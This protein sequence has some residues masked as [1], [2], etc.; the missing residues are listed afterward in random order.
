MKS[1][2]QKHIVE[3]IWID[4]VGQ[5]RSKN[6][7]YAIKPSS[8]QDITLWSFDGSSTG[9]A[10]THHSER[11]LKPVYLCNN[12]FLENSSLVLCAVYEDFECTIPALYNHYHKCQEVLNQ[13][14]ETEPWFGFEQ[15]YFL[16]KRNHTNISKTPLGIEDLT[17]CN[18]QGQYY[19]SI[20]AQNAF[21]R[22]IV[23]THLQYCLKAG[24]SIYGSNAEVAPGQ[25]EFQIGTVEGIE[26]AHQL[27]ISRYILLRVSEMFDCCVEFH[28]KP[29][30]HL[31]GSGCHTNFSTKATRN[32]G[33]LEIMTRD[34]FP[35][36]E[37]THKEHIENYGKHNELRLTGIHET[38]SIHS[39]SWAVA[40]RG[41]SIRVGIETF[42]NACGYFED[43]RPASNCDPYLV[44]ML[45]VKNTHTKLATD[46]KSEY[47]E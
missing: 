23:E 13:Y 42:K 24:I 35:R 14:I 11:F 29:F 9:Q 17:N 15:E 44:S 21:G 7:I 33:G 8:V 31:N 32:G 20:G 37:S 12:P 19:C 6:K 5:L 22:F 43:R 2:V 28:P 47:F 4:A 39:F 46:V 41:T 34:I 25:W 3:Y 45:L 1:I 38:A 40:S 36:L 18:D 26:A 16:L 30:Q 27:W 10:E